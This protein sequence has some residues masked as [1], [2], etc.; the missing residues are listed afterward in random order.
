MKIEVPLLNAVR[1]T[2]VSASV[3]YVNTQHVHP[4][5]PLQMNALPALAVRLDSSRPTLRLATLRQS[6]AV[7]T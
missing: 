1:F 7:Q 3:L 4:N 5:N 6:T 2:P